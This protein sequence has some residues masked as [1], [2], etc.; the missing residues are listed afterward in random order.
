MGRRVHIN[1]AD[2]VVNPNV[3]VEIYSTNVVESEGVEEGDKQQLA[4]VVILDTDDSGDLSGDK[5]SC[6]FDVVAYEGQVTLEMDFNPWSVTFS[7]K[8]KFVF[9]LSCPFTVV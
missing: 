7:E 4:K 2:I 3:T 5:S 8:L 1:L 9:N 6:L